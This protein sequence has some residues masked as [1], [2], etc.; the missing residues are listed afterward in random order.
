NLTL[1]AAIIPV[2]ISRDPARE[3]PHQPDQ[4]NQNTEAYGDRNPHVGHRVSSCIEDAP[5]PRAAP[6]KALKAKQVPR[7]GGL[8]SKPIRHGY[9]N[10]GVLTSTS[11][12]CVQTIF[13]R[14]LSASCRPR[15]DWAT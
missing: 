11:W 8:P 13:T 10:V 9:S 14:S 12:I 15:V 5:P 6:R 3:E 1:A 7:T 4:S 2:R